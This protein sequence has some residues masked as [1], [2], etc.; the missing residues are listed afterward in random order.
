MVCLATP[1]AGPHAQQRRAPRLGWLGAGRAAEAAAHRDSLR[2]ALVGYVSVAALII[3]ERHAEGQNERLPS[4]AREIVRLRP[5]VIFA[6]GAAAIGAAR[7][8]SGTLPIVALAA[9]VP[10]S[11]ARR[12]TTTVP[13]NVTAV[14]FENAVLS[15]QRLEVLRDIVPTVKR[16]GVLTY[17]GDAL[18]ALDLRETQMA[19]EKLGVAV[20]A[21]EAR[22]PEALARAL[23]S[24]AP[25]RPEA[26]IVPGSAA[27][28][29]PTDQIVGVTVRAK[30]P[31]IFAFREFVDAGAL[32][33]F[34]PNLD[35]LY[36]RAGTLIGKALVGVP[37]RDLPVEVPSRFELVVSRKAARALG[38]D[39]PPSLVRRADELV[40]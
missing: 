36:R 22:D 13:P 9:R 7:E 8:A 33:S 25:T 11:E 19:G 24:A 39:I 34:G 14:T 35:A 37:P 15:Q 5:D 38:L 27:A 6:V 30:L 21:L 40:K 18:G 26:L 12:G 28:F 4:L 16:V 23:L 29:W 17:P 1:V 3:D 10:G 32:A 2:Q 20:A 31:A